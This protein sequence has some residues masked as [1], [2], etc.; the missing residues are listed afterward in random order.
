MG[1]P[2]IS[3]FLAHLANTRKIS[4][5]TQNQAFSAILF[6]YR[7]VLHIELDELNLADFALINRKMFLLFSQKKRSGASLATFPVSTRSLLK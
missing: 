1:V 7:Y 2:E 3:Q 6:L 4:A 5:S